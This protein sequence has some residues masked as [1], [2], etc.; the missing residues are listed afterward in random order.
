MGHCW[1]FNPFTHCVN[2]QSV[3][4]LLFCLMCENQMMMM[5]MI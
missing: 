1:P 5:M 3:L 2:A 4:V